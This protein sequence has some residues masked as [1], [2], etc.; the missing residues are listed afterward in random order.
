MPLWRRATTQR[1]RGQ[2]DA[3][4]AID[5]RLQVL[6]HKERGFAARAAQYRADAAAKGREPRGRQT[7][8]NML[9]QAAVFD[10]SAQSLQLQRLNLEQQRLALD[11]SATNA[12]T[13]QAQQTMAKAT[14]V[15]HAVTDPD[16]VHDL[17][18]TMEDQQELMREVGDA[19]AAPSVSSGHDADDFE[20]ELA[21]LLGEPAAEA[22]V[23][24]PAALP[25][26]GPDT[27]HLRDPPSSQ[28]RP[29][30]A[31]AAAVEE[32]ALLAA[33]G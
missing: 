23:D 22:G 29:P 17:R 26:L 24:T 14:A 10:D 6:E 20:D 30:A 7:A 21:A 28:R 11:M 2:A 18:D 12:E 4:G 27:Q 16:A 33:F 9:R 19:L 3:M 25:F 1:S 8:L 13:I 15:A 31:P 32:D 5:D